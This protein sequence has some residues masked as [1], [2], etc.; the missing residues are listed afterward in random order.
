MVLTIMVHSAKVMPKD[1]EDSFIKEGLFIKGKLGTMSLKEKVFLSM[2][3]KNIVIWEV[4]STIYQMEKVSNIGEMDLT[5]KETFLMV[6]NTGKESV[7]FLTVLLMKVLSS[8]I[9]SMV[10]AAYPLIKANIPDSFN[11]ENF[12]VRDYFN[13]KMDRF[14][15]VITKMIKSMDLANILILKEKCLKGI[16]K[17]ERE[18]ATV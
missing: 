9:N 18:M 4:G 17:M 2:I 13:G 6:K 1:K 14:M 16:G 11:K 12:K 8:M 7:N 5:I 3:Y 10:K 15:R